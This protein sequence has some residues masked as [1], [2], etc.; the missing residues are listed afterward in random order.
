[1]IVPWDIWDSLGAW[2]G[3]RL[4]Y[5]VENSIGVLGDSVLI[6]S[7]LKLGM[8]LKLEKCLNRR[9]L[10]PLTPPSLCQLVIPL[11]L[12]LASQSIPTHILK[13]N[14]TQWRYSCR[15]RRKISSIIGLECMLVS[16]LTRKRFSK[17]AVIFLNCLFL[18]ISHMEIIKL[19][20]V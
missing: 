10:A 19:I 20:L 6:N 13:G 16:L 12:S 18:S 7:K 2:W 15:K 1:M 4:Q 11:L 14:I 3:H 9:H 17:W 5:T 8:F